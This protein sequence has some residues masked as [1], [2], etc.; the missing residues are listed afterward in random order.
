MERNHL[1]Q[2]FTLVELLVVIAIIGILVGLLLP[3]VQAARE[4][5]RRMQCS[6]NLKQLA[7]AAHNYESSNRRFPAM[8]TGTGYVGGGAQNFSMSGW[9]ALLPYIEQTAL[10]NS[11]STLNVDSTQYVPGGT[12]N[13]ISMN[14]LASRIPALECPSDAGSSDPSSAALTLTLTSYGMCTGDNYA[15]S[16]LPNESSNASLAMQK[17]A[18]RNRGLF[19]RGD[20]PAMGRMTDGTSNT[21]MLAERS[22][23]TSKNSKGAAIFLLAN[24]ATMPP[25]ACQANW[26]GNRYVD[27]SLVYMSDSMPG[28]RGMAGNAYYTAV[29]TI[30]APN[31]AVCVVSGGA[32][33]LAAGGIWSATSEHT[34]GVQA[35]MGDGSVHFFSQSI[36]AGDPSI[37]PPSGTG[38]GISPYGVWGALGTTSG[39]EVVSVPE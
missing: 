13:G 30:L 32:S 33:P 34:G 11:L 22:R 16:Q 10:Y 35:A 36:N 8:E 5:A 31:S 39:S 26:A 37:P 4:A 2:A 28:Y 12:S 25:S 23:P 29:S 20:Y 38:G 6:N 17:Q 14:M 24:P 27:D 3:A 15:M 1:R 7:L 19:G 21:I 9:Y 18:I